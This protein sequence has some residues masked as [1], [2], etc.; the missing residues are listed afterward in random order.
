MFSLAACRGGEAPEETPGETPNETPGETPTG[1]VDY[2]IGIITGTVSQGEEEYQAAQNML[3]KYGEKIVTAT[4]PD[5]FSSETE[6]TIAN[7]VAYGVIAVSLAM[8]AWK[9]KVKPK[10]Q[11]PTTG[12]KEEALEK[13]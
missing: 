6:T 10:V 8:H 7:V 2:K 11:G 4:Y 13:A 3:K 1:D 9:G 5:N 12:L